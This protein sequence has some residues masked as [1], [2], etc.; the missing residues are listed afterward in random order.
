[1]PEQE[2]RAQPELGERE[3]ELIA[4]Q[5]THRYPWTMV[6]AEL[7]RDAAATMTRAG[8]SL[9]LTPVGYGAGVRLSV[10]DL[11][12]RTWGAVCLNADELDLLCRALTSSG[13][14]EWVERHLEAP[15]RPRRRS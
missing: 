10:S 1:M 11:R 6:N 8:Y 15:R 3:L 9:R 12:Y 13:A 14:V 5:S 4:S 2:D 7:L